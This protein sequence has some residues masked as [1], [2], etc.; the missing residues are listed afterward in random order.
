VK[1]CQTDCHNGCD[2]ICDNAVDNISK[3]RRDAVM[4]NDAEIKRLTNILDALRH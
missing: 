1:V 3:E 4:K 2:K